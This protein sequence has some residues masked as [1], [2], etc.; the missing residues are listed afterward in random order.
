MRNLL[1]LMVAAL[2]VVF[3]AGGLLAGQDYNPKA[4]LKQVQA[5]QKGERKALKLKQKNLRH[6]LKS[7]PIPKATRVQ[8]KHQAARERRDLRQKQ[9]DEL[10]QMKDRQRIVRESQR[11]YGQGR[12]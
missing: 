2:V 3:S 5:H 6:Y 10:Q 1:N 4:H 9:K 11:A 12:M 8:M 7:Q